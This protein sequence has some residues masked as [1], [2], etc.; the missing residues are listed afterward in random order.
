MAMVFT[1]VS[2]A[3]ERLTDLVEQ[4]EKDRQEEEE[5]K[6]KEKE[7]AEAV[8]LILKTTYHLY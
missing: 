8:S 1:L 6:L 5:R 2:G 3:Q 4:I 7:E